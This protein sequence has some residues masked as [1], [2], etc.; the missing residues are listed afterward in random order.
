MDTP[1]VQ[2]PGAILSC[3]GH[4]LE[5]RGGR[6]DGGDP[7]EHEMPVIDDRSADL[8]VQLLRAAGVDNGVVGLRQGGVQVAQPLRLLI[9]KPR[10]S[11]VA[12]GAPIAA[13]QP[14]CIE[15]GFA[16]HQ[17]VEGLP[18]VASPDQLEVAKAP[19]L[20]QDLL[21]RVPIGRSHVHERE[22]PALLADKRRKP[23]DAPV[24]GGAFHTR[25]AQILVLLPEPVGGH[26]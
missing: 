20:G 25:E 24:I 11:H 13:E 19:A 14:L 1:L 5:Q 6:I 22:V 2:Q 18:I 10:R 4:V 3:P 7:T 9:G 15:H 21:M 8:P 26:L 16:V 23:R 12:G 17:D